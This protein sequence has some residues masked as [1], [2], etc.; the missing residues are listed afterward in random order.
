MGFAEEDVAEKSGEKASREDRKASP[1][2]SPIT[3]QFSTPLPRVHLY[4]RHDPLFRRSRLYHSPHRDLPPLKRRRSFP[5]QPPAASSEPRR[6]RTI[7]RPLYHLQGLVDSG[8]E[9]GSHGLRPFPAM[10]PLRVESRAVRDLCP[11]IYN[12]ILVRQ[13]VDH[14]PLGRPSHMVRHQHPRPFLE[15]STRHDQEPGHW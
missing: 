6:S 3:L 4:P 7:R 2:T 10:H 12:P 15:R 13:V 11:T 9:N 14:A 1:T 5:S 8:R